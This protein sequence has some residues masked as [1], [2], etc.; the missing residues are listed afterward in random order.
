MVIFG[1]LGLAVALNAINNAWIAAAFQGA[2]LFGLAI[3]NDGVRTFMRFLA[4]I[5]IPVILVLM[6]PDYQATGD[7]IVLVAAIVSA[8]VNAY[9]IWALGQND[10]RDWMFRKNFDLGD[11]PPGDDVP[12]L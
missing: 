6:I 12:K 11:G 10:V 1:L 4:T 2:L 5:N 9:I 8:A 7:A 3:G